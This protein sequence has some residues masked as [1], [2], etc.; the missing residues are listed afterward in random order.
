ML[1]AKVTFKNISYYPSFYRTHF[2]KG[3][4][5]NADQAYYQQLTRPLL[6]AFHRSM[7]LGELGSLDSGNFFLCRHEDRIMW[8][9]VGIVAIFRTM[10]HI[11]FL[12]RNTQKGSCGEVT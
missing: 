5:T 10:Y 6:H 12:L 7:K 4:A 2:G 9:Q 1:W 11:S 3:V 8:I